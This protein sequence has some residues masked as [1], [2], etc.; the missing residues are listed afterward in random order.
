[1][2]EYEAAQACCRKLETPAMVTSCLVEKAEIRNCL[3]HLIEVG[4][5]KCKEDQSARDEQFWKDLKRFV[6]HL[7]ELFLEVCAKFLLSQSGDVLNPIPVLPFDSMALEL[8][9][10]RGAV[11]C[12]SASAASTGYRLSGAVAFDVGGARLP[13]SMQFA[14]LPAPSGIDEGVRQVVSCC[15]MQ[16]QIAGARVDLWLDADEP[17]FVFTRNG[18]EYLGLAMMG[19]ITPPTFD[20]AGVPPEAPMDGDEKKDPCAQFRTLPPSLTIPLPRSIWMELPLN[21]EGARVLVGSQTVL[22]TDVVFPHAP[23][24]TAD[25]NADLTVDGLDIEAF[26]ADPPALR[27]L[28]GDG[29][30]SAHDEAHFLERWAAAQD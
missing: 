23:N 28:D 13:M 11:D 12:Q 14:V 19:A 9:G 15:A 3:T 27:D 2:Q 1:M 5:L 20:G 25:W 10:Q 26:Y 7:A 8:S 24:P 4:F 21:R 6:A 29:H 16:V 30:Y 22:A 18:S 17:S